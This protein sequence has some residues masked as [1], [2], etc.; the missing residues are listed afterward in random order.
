[1]PAKRIKIK[2]DV[3][4]DRLVQAE[5]NENDA[6]PLR[7]SAAKLCAFCKHSYLRPCSEK[8]YRQCPNWK[9]LQGRRK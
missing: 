7:S 8:T 3:D 5:L 2:D 4:I 9:H 6:K 1:M